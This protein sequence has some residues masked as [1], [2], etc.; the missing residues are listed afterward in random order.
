MVLMM[1]SEDSNLQPSTHMPEDGLPIFPF[2]FIPGTVLIRIFLGSAQVLDQLRRACD[3][4]EEKSDCTAE[5]L[6]RRLVRFRIAFHSYPLL[7]DS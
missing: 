2:D 7:D 3:V 1:G 6:W 5:K 4:G